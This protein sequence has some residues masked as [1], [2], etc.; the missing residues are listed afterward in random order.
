MNI[1]N[2]WQRRLFANLLEEI[3]VGLI[4]NGDAHHLAAGFLQAA[5]LTQVPLHIGKGQIKHRL[6]HAGS[7]AAQSDR[8]YH[9][10]TCFCVGSSIR[11]V[12]APIPKYESLNILI[13]H[14]QEE[15]GKEHDAHGR[16]IA[17][18]AKRNYLTRYLLE[19]F[20]YKSAAVKRGNGEHVHEAQG[21]RDNGREE[22][23]IQE[24]RIQGAFRHNRNAHHRS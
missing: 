17:Q 13:D 2:N 3:Q 11:H 21:C 10:L 24:A 9:D 8:T 4:R 5:Y 12:L 19:Y 15:S 22:Q 20:H 6:N 16:H 7:A 23:E 1:C 18:G 14:N